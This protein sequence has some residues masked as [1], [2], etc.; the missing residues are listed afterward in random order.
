MNK[1]WYLSQIN[2]ME[3]LTMED[4]QEI[5][6]RAPMSET[7]KGTVISSPE[8][9]QRSLYLLKKGKVRLYK[10]NREGKEFTLGI[11]G[12]GNFFGEVESFSTGTQDTYVETME[13]SLLCVLNRK[14]FEEFMRERPQLAI[15]MVQ[16]MTQRLREA[17]EMLETMAYGSVEKRLLHLLS[18]LAPNFGTKKG[19]YMEFDLR[20]SHQDLA[21]M[22]GATRETVSATIS[23]L[24]RQGVIAKSSN[25]K[26]IRIHIE[27]MR[28]A[29]D[30]G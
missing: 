20:L 18:K 3:E 16:V 4:L 10:L 15:K 7:S 21:A 11:L 1:L 5:D 8:R 27:K 9:P 25:K 17:E 2:I 28:E 26:M 12:S 19:E 24:T 30:F 13:D 29:I 6:R 23:N 22:I 14:D